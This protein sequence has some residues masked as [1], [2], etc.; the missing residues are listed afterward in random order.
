MNGLDLIAAHM[1]GDFLFQTSYMA[2][3]KLKSWG[4]ESMARKRLH[5][6]LSPP[7]LPPLGTTHSYSSPWS[8]LHIS[9]LI[10]SG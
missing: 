5:G 7:S 10:L 6:M 2:A 3:N 8:G 4:G 9:L 1:A